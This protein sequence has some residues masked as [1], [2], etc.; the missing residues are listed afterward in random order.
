MR[1]SRHLIFDLDYFLRKESGASF[2]ECAL[3][4]SIVVVVGCIVLIAWQKIW[5]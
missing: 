5:G 4:A 2:S 3:V 1:P